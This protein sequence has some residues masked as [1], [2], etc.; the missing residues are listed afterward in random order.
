MSKNVLIV[1]DSKM[2]R[3]MIKRAMGELGSDWAFEEAANW[4]EALAKVETTSFDLV[5]ID[6]NMP[7]KDG[8]E[9]TEILRGRFPDLAMAL[10]TANVQASV[11]DH[12]KRLNIPV[13][14]KPIK[15]EDL[16]AFLSG[17]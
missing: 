8:L 7:G 12:G 14:G 11:Q 5:F 6:V 1:D 16:E 10:V 3:M 13:F 15:K 9:L 17:V 4:E 2:A